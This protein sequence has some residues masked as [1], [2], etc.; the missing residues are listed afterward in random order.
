[1]AVGLFSSR[2]IGVCGSSKGL[3]PEAAEFCRA[4]GRRLARDPLAKIVSGG[5]KKRRGTTDGDLAADWWIVS[6]AR[7]AMDGRAAFERIVTVV[8]DETD[9]AVGFH[10]GT[11][12][13]ARGKTSEARR[14]TF[15]RDVDALIAVAG[16]RGTDQ[17][18]ALAIEHD[19]RV[20][21]VPSFGGAA[22]EFWDAYRSD[23]IKSLRI[24]DR[25]ARRWEATPP[26]A[27]A[28]LQALAN[29]MVDVLFDSLPRRCFVVM[30]FH[31]D[32]D[33]LFDFVIA[34]AVMAAGDEPIRVDR[35]GTPGDVTKQIE[36]GIKNCEYVIAVLDNLRPNVLYELGVA[37]G[38]EKV[39]ILLNRK[40]SPE[41]AASVPFD[42]F[43]QQRLEYTK[44]DSELP[45]RLEALIR[46]V[47]TRRR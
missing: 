42:L 2:R 41:S 37:H 44:L 20:L 28:P 47:S 7:D 25:V 34:P 35:V 5:A 40:G 24:D 26:G 9:D 31:E 27:A 45:G 14:I 1:M 13:R 17:E 22:R 23:L 29:D 15:V 32:F 36:D 6:F 43:T 33:G 18:L 4:L 12:Q 8:R 21:P 16:R 3:T 46:S 39:T 10:I 30:P 11:E 38:R 19:I